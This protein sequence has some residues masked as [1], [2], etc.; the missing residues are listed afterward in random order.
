MSGPASAPLPVL[1]GGAREH[2]LDLL[3]R[4][5]QPLNTYIGIALVLGIIY[6]GKIPDSF[7][8]QANHFM[9]RL[10]MFT[11]TIIVADTYSWIY[12]LLMALFTVLLIAVAPR[13]SFEGFQSSASSS[14]T[15]VKLVTQK[16]KWWSEEVLLENPLGIE[17][18]KVRTQAIQDGGNSSSSTTSSQQA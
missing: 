13:A 9:G 15:D 5:A 12:G 7:T 1:K 4:Y 2:T 11:L 8:N 10:F 3:Q 18:E 14:D 16:K 6:V 17:E